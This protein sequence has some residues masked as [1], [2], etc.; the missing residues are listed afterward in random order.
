M[1]AVENLYLHAYISSIAFHRGTDAHTVVGARG[2]LELEAVDEIGIFVNGVE[3]AAKCLAWVHA[4]GA[5]L[6][7]IVNGVARPLIHIGAVKEYLEAFFLLLLGELERFGTL[8]FLHVDVA[9]PYFAAMCLQLE[10]L[11]GENGL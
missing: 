2:E 8:E 10:L 1:L 5:V 3:V 11:D 4:D 9:E 7:G 6:D